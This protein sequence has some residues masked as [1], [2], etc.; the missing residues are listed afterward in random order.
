[1]VSKLRR[2]LFFLPDCTSHPLS[3]LWTKG[4][5]ELLDLL[6]HPDARAVL[7]GQATADLDGRPGDAWPVPSNGLKTN[8]SM[9]AGGPVVLVGSGTD[10]VAI[11]AA[12]KRSLSPPFPG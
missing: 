1:L 2:F 7:D 3:Q 6:D 9:D 4:Y 11:H 8:G 12:A 10:A 5:A